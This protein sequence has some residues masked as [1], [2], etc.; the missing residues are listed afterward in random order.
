MSLSLYAYRGWDDK[1]KEMIDAGEVDINEIGNGGNTPLHDACA[2]GHY[3]VLWQEI[4]VC[5]E[6]I[7][8]EC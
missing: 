6:M 3:K 4:G 7:N 2:N 1:V 5:K 8:D